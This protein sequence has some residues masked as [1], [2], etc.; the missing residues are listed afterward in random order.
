M[1]IAVIGHKRVPS[2]EGGI[3]KTVEKQT[4]RMCRHG[5]EVILY[6]RSGHNI[7]GEEFDSDPAGGTIARERNLRIES[8]P[9]PKGFPGVPVYSLLATIRALRESC[10]VV[11]YHGS[12]S[13]LMI[14]LAK[15]FGVSCVAFIHGIDS[16]QKK[17]N[18]FG[19]A[20][21]RLGEKAAAKKADVCLVLSENNQTYIRDKYGTDPVLTFNGTE[22]P[23]QTDNAQELLEKNF[24]LKKEEYILN[25]GRIISGKGLEYLIK[26]FR[27]CKTEKKLVIAGGVDPVCRTY[28]R[29]LQELA[30]GDP[31]IRFLGFQDESALNILY[32]LAYAFVFPSDH[33]G[34]AHSLL[35]AMAAGCCCL[36][37]DIPENS[38]VVKEH[39]LCFRQGN[40][41]DL[42]EKLQ[43]LLDS[44]ET[45][46]KYREGVAEYALKTYNWDDCVAQIEG[47]MEKITAGKKG[48]AEPMQTRSY[49]SVQMLKQINRNIS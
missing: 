44:R 3:E 13:C 18:W 49:E 17:W 24:G 34:M 46:V 40:A 41:E 37:S 42:R 38:S 25:T 7:F 22:R 2:R 8:V 23:P 32:E 33:E 29:E 26:A 35:E 4:I 43:M 47:I 15:I 27:S 30:K 1:R 9:T 11:Y 20:Y 10:D 5:H 31:R 14:P 21:L 36:V 39:G 48:S 28:Y 12:G 16:K 45:V 6:N 19:K